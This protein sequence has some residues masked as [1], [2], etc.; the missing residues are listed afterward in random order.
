[1]GR[2]SAKSAKA[3]DISGIRAMAPWTG[4][5]T[6]AMRAKAQETAVHATAPASG[7]NEQA[8]LLGWANVVLEFSPGAS[9]F[10]LNK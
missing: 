3:L 9:L 10:N 1:M 2:A 8:A 5:P 7:D 6:T 4:I